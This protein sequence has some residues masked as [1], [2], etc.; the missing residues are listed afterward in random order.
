VPE[1]SHLVAWPVSD[2]DERFPG[3]PPLHPKPVRPTP[4][5]LTGER[6]IATSNAPGMKQAALGYSV[7]D[8]TRHT[9]L[10]GPSGVGKSTILL[11]LIIQ[12]LEAGRPVVVIEPK[13]LV[14]RSA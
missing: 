1:L 8:S 11:N 14:L 9:W 3:Q 6:V 5:L 2:K 10:L 7:T 4:A 12:D 13:D